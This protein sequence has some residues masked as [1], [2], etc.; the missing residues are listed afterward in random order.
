MGLILLNSDVFGLLLCSALRLSAVRALLSLP[1]L[2]FLRIFSRTI[3]YLLTSS[4]VVAAA[5]GNSFSFPARS[6]A[7]SVDSV[8][9]CGLYRFPPKNGQPYFASHFIMG[10]EKFDSPQPESFLFGENPDLNYLGSRPVSFPYPPP[11][12][13]E[14]TKVLKSQM[15]IRKDSVHFVPAA[16]ASDDEAGAEEADDDDEENRRY[17]VEFT[18]DSDV[19]CNINLVYFC[20]EE[21]HSQGVNLVS[22]R[23]ELCSKTFEYGRGACQVFSQPSHVFVPA[24]CKN[25]L[26]E[27]DSDVISLAIQCVSLE[28]DR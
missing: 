22:R 2:H 1:C 26:L 18:F 13:N 15:Q 20:T 19:R 7:D 21:T 3:L 17:N 5:M 27:D 8:G 11:A 24:K 14:P 28:G 9:A 12:A 16:D 23:K 10:G 4:S 25:E 6:A